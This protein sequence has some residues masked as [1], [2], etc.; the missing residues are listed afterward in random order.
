MLIIGQDSV[1]SRLS[2]RDKLFLLFPEDAPCR[3][4][5]TFLSFTKNTNNYAVLEGISI[6]QLAHAIGVQKAVIIALPE[7]SGFVSSIKRSLN[8]L[9][10]IEGGV[11]IE[12]S[13][14][15]RACQN[16]RTKQQGDDENSL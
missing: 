4:E 8:H 16:I 14:N 3:S 6:E 13:E 5:K 9:G 1:K 15:I 10:S 11:P 7:R 2:C 12:Q